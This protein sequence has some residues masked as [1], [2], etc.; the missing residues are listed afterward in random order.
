MLVHGREVIDAP[1]D[2]VVACLG[3]ETKELLGEVFERA[4][5]ESHRLL[6]RVG[7]AGS[8]R[9][10]SKTVDVRSTP[11]RRH[12]GS[13]L[14]SFCWTAWDAGELF[15]ALQADLEL[16]PIGDAKTELLLRGSYDPP[17]GRLGHNLDRLFLH[18]LVDPTISA[19][20]A[21]MS[22]ALSEKVADSSTL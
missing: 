14:L 11:L 5:A 18:H 6:A 7:P 3:S 1:F 2:K 10:F 21:A 4:R 16:A 8:L 15:P 22:T 12:E 17:A 9:T 20:M 13:V 19:F